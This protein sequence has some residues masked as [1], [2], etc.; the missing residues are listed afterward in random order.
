MAGEYHVDEGL[1]QFEEDETFVEVETSPQAF[2]KRAV[3][4]G[5]SDGIYIEVVSGLS[6][7]DR[8]KNPQSVR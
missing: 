8:I 2:E 7:T 5:L 6:E 4:T 1:L 3:E